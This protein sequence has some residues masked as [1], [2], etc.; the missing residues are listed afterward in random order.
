MGFPSQFPVLLDKGSLVEIDE[1]IHD[2]FA[3]KHIEN[4]VP[5]VSNLIR[6]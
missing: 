4:N 2:T 5:S 6:A 1:T 3:D